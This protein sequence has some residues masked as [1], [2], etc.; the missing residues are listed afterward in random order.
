LPTRPDSSTSATA[1]QSSARASWRLSMWRANAGLACPDSPTPEARS[2]R[3]STSFRVSGVCH[4]RSA[5]QDPGSSELSGTGTGSPPSISAQ[6][7]V[8]LGFLHRCL[9]FSHRRSNTF[10]PPWQSAPP[11]QHRLP[12]LR[13]ADV[14]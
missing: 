5:H 12:T 7:V 14:G 2:G 9:L 1:K 6:A 10:A 13:C 11:H 4:A 3:R 8:T